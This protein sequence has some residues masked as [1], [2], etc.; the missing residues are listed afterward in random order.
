[1]MGTMRLKT[2]D[3]GFWGVDLVRGCLIA[4]LVT[5]GLELLKA[6]ACYVVF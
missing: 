2:A 4:S 3:S 6:G 1:M 5:Q